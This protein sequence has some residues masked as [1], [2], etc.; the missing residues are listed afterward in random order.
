MKVELIELGD[1]LAELGDELAELGHGRKSWLGSCGT[2]R[3]GSRW[4]L[5]KMGK[6]Q[7]TSFVPVRPISSV[8]GKENSFF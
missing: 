7:Y 6:T 1:E 2:S 8:T 5:L 3:V 4:N